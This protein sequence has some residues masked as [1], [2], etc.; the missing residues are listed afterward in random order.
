MALEKGQKLVKIYHGT[1]DWGKQIYDSDFSMTG[2]LAAHRE[3][4][5]L[6][7]TISKNIICGAFLRSKR[8]VRYK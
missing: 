1:L 8:Q 3:K 7:V 6:N 4:C 2:Q 5:C